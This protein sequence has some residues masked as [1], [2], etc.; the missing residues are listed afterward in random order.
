MSAIRIASLRWVAAAALIVGS[1][2]GAFA[3]YMGPFGPSEQ[4]IAPVGQYREG[5]RFGAWMF[6]PSI[7]VG[8]VYDD[9]TSQ[10]TGHDSG[11]SARVVPNLSAVWN[12][13]THQTTI[14]G[15]ADARFFDAN[16]V[17]ATTGFAHSYEPTRDV[18]LSVQGNYQRQTD[19][20]NNAL[21]FNNGAIGPTTS[22]T[23]TAPL[24]INPFGTTPGVNPI[25]NNQFTLSGSA[26]NKFGPG[27]NGFVSL[28]G[29][30]YYL[31]FDHQD[32]LGPNNPFQTSH[33]GANYQ[34]GGR[35]GYH[36]LSSIYVFA[37]STG[38]FQRFNN[39]VFDTNG[40]RV[41]G[42]IGSDDPQKLLTGQIYG[43]YQAQFATN[44][45]LLNGTPGVDVTGI[46]GIPV[47]VPSG[48]PQNTD[49]SVF[50]GRIYYF[51]T[52][53]WTLLAQVD[54]TL[55]MGSILQP[56]V[57]AGTPTR[58]ITSLLQTNYALTR[59]LSVGARLGYTHGT[60]IGIDRVDN[61]YMGGASLNYEVW[62]NLLATLDYQYS[63]VRSTAPLSD[64]TRNVYTAGLTYHY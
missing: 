53:R 35:I 12:T 31:A 40:Y 16:T 21:N 47:N 46:G 58:T 57:P 32:D 45:Q 33:D 42:G 44:N 20:F 61:G 7:F 17:S 11:F 10:L 19:I 30:A 55:G 22:P 15:V 56:N 14:Y 37:D 4:E 2:P 9:N 6:Y 29:A 34:V 63:T 43:G 18:I 41:T 59:V 27:G 49:S 28:F 52:R 60:F 62:R 38:I 50:G 25:A 48:I 23:S 54:E 39:S 5:I 36:V 64:F 26:T 8:G 51:P 13:Q 1:I 24:F 3:Q